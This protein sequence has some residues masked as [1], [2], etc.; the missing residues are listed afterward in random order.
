MSLEARCGNKPDVKA[1]NVEP[2]SCPSRIGQFRP[3]A[4]NRDRRPIACSL[5]SL[6]ERVVGP[7][8]A[9]ATPSKFHH[10]LHIREKM[11]SNGGAV[12]R[13]AHPDV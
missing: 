4:T 12:I 3:S 11:A 6:E 9:Q 7:T 13:K 8:S 1:C 5:G 10:R 2:V